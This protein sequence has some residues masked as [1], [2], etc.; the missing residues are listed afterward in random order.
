MSTPRVRI[1]AEVGSNYDG[2]LE[3]AKYYVRAAAEKGA[4]VVKFQTLTKETLIAPR[5]LIPEER[6]TNT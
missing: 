5:G 3:T 6:V 1:I 2:S 4:D